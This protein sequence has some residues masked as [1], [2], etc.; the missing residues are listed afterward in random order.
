[1]D[2]EDGSRAW[3][4]REIFLPPSGADWELCGIVPD[5]EIPLDW[6]EYTAETDQQLQTA[7]E[8][9]LKIKED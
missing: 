6:D 3:L 4:A 7:L 8:W 5:L 2:F 1:V 9:L